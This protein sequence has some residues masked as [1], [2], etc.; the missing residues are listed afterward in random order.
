[1]FISTAMTH[2][3]DEEGLLRITR[4]QTILRITSQ[5]VMGHRLYDY[6]R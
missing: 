2:I 3:Q 1:M 4:A 6:D 5:P